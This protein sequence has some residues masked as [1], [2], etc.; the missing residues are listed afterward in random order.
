MQDNIGRFKDGVDLCRQIQTQ[1]GQ[2]GPAEGAE[3][4]IVLGEH[5]MYPTNIPRMVSLLNA[6]SPAAR[7]IRLDSEV[8]L[9]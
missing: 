7:K 1:P 3:T 2:V 4:R 5:I 9:V 8:V 6:L